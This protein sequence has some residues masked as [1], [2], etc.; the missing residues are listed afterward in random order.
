MAKHDEDTLSIWLSEAIDI[1]TRFDDLFYRVLLG[2]DY[3]DNCCWCGAE[4]VEVDIPGE[5][6]TTCKH[7]DD[8]LF[9]EAHNKVLGLHARLTKLVEDRIQS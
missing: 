5:Y 2:V 9:V 4:I 3:E 6:Q 1:A 7:H 8:C